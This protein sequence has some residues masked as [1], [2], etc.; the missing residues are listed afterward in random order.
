MFYLNDQLLTCAVSCKVNMCAFQYKNLNTAL[1]W[2]AQRL[3]DDL[4]EYRKLHSNNTHGFNW[5]FYGTGEVSFGD[6]EH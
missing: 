6:R 4:Y 1:I 2:S 3:L 5:N